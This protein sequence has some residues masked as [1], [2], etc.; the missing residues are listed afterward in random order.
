MSGKVEA[1]NPTSARWDLNP[2]IS[3]V[4]YTP[5]FY[6]EFPTRTGYTFNGW[7]VTG[8]D[9]NIHHGWYSSANQSS[10][11][12]SWAN[13]SAFGNSTHEYY[14]LRAT[15]GTV[16]FSANWTNNSYS[17]SYTLNGGS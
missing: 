4:T 17:I 9:S 13:T 14:N 15:A 2:N 10:N 11:A 3:G 6:I 16:T 5:W 8:M 12:T 1:L 7:T